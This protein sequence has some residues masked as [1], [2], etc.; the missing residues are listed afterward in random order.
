M[1]YAET[2]DAQNKANEVSINT[3]MKTSAL[4]TTHTSETSWY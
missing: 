2:L 4:N 1:S 3:Q